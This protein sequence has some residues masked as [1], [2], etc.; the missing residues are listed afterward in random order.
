ME[1]KRFMSFEFVTAA[2]N[3]IIVFWD[4]RRVDGGKVQTFRKNLQTDD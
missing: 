3:K 2:H 4:K 1:F